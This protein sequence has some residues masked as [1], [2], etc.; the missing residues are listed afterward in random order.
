MPPPSVSECDGH[1]LLGIG[2]TD[3]VPVQLLD[4]FAGFHVFHEH[5]VVLAIQVCGATGFWDRG[6]CVGTING[7]GGGGGDGGFGGGEV[8]D[9]F[10]Q[11]TAKIQS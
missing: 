5:H 7:G 11:S 10:L 6:L 2:L 1:C 9:V 4:D 3:N 8:N